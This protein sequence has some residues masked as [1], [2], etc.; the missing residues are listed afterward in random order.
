MLMI[1][2]NIDSIIYVIIQYIP[3]SIDII[4]ISIF[5]NN[6]KYQELIFQ[7][8][9]DKFI[10]NRNLYSGSMPISANLNMLIQENIIINGEHN[11]SYISDAILL[12]FL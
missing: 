12:Q 7:K 3:M 9:Q 5:H 10:L 2:Y 4:K 11:E 8:I 1:K 6:I